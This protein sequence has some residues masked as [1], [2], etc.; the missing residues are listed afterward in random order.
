MK[1]YD[2]Q[3]KMLVLL[4]KLHPNIQLSTID[5]PKPV[6]LDALD[7]PSSNDD[8]PDDNSTVGDATN[9]DD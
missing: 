9:L 8:S 5:R 1:I 7:L 3:V 6:D 4:S 2:N